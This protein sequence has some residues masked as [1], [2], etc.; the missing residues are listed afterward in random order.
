MKWFAQLAKAQT[1]YTCHLQNSYCDTNTQVMIQDARPNA[2]HGVD[3]KSQHD[4]LSTHQPIS[5]H[6]STFTDMDEW[7]TLSAKADRQHLPHLPAVQMTE[8]SDT[9]PDIATIQI[10]DIDTIEPSIAMAKWQQS[11]NS[12]EAESLKQQKRQTPTKI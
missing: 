8:E 6:D 10:V 5:L 11:P 1:D 9:P 4:M 3:N 7:L 2:N 12:T